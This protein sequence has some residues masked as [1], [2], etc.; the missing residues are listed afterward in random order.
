MTARSTP[1]RT[2]RSGA[3]KPNRTRRS[4]N[5]KTKS[6]EDKAMTKISRNKLEKALRRANW[7]AIRNSQFE[8]RV[9]IN[10]DGKIA[11]QEWPEGSN[12]YFKNESILYT[13]CYWPGFCPPYGPADAIA[14]TWEQHCFITEAMPD[15]IDE[16]SKDYEII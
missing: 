10:L 12:G 1:N 13:C 6:K 5:P 8:Y 2:R 9:V 14:I 16:I 4:G 7:S 3:S 15:I 11:V